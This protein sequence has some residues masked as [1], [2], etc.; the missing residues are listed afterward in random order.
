MLILVSVAI[1]LLWY[2]RRVRLRA[3][4]PNGQ[5]W[6]MMATLRSMPRWDQERV[7]YVLGGG[8]LE[9]AGLVMLL[10]FTPFL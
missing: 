8:A 10:S 5:R 9:F 6:P 4:F 7:M 3:M 1:G 2:G